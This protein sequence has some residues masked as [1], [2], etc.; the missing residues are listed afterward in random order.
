MSWVRTL[1]LINLSVFGIC[2]LFTF[3]GIH[4]ENFF[5]LYPIKSDYFSPYQLITHLFIH[6]N[7]EHLFF[8]M[9]FFLFCGIEV[10]KYLGKNF[11]SFYFLSGLFS[12]GLYCLGSDSPMIGA[13]GAV[14]SVMTFSIFIPIKT[15]KFKTYLTLKLKSLFLIFFIISELYYALTIYNDNIGHWA[16]IFGSIFGIIYYLYLNFAQPKA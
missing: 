9:L 8:N 12:S 14:F 5:A 3:W 15:K 11:I 4:L 10:E 1:I 13:S 7:A 16:H 2:N 6:G